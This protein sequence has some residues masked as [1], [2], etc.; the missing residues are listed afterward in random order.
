MRKSALLVV[1]MLQLRLKRLKK[2]PWRR[3]C[4]WEGCA[5]HL[6]NRSPARRLGFDCGKVD[7]VLRVFEMAS[8]QIT[9]DFA[10]HV[11]LLTISGG[12]Y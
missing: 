7:S 11:I 2:R 3:G 12:S 1:E 8:S 10:L 4:G 9:Y 6:A 5:C